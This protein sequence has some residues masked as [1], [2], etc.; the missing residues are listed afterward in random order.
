VDVPGLP[1]DSLVDFR[2]KHV[3]AG[4][5]IDDYRRWPREYGPKHLPFRRTDGWLIL[6]APYSGFIKMDDHRRAQW[7]NPHDILTAVKYM[8]IK[9]AEVQQVLT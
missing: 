8:L 9:V 4:T 3:E 6:N 7:N 5:W 2:N 1:Y